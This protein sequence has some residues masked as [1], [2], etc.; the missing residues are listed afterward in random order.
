VVIRP[1]LRGLVVLTAYGAVVGGVV[2]L[3]TAM[4]ANPR[5]DDLSFYWKL[6]TV[7]ALASV[8]ASLAL[9][10]LT[11]PQELFNFLTT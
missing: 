2:G 5:P 4:L 1:S 6:Y 9:Q 3:V 10:P 11:I 8:G 7:I